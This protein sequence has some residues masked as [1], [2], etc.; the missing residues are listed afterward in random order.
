MTTSGLV[1]ALGLTA[2]PAAV[3]AWVLI[4]LLKPVM[5]RLALAKPNARSSHRLPTPQ[6][7]GLG[8][9][10]AALVVSGTGL[11]LTT[12]IDQAFGLLGLAVLGLTVLGFADDASP[13]AWRLKLV[14]QT[15]CCA[16][17]VAG[18]PAGLRLVPV[19]ILFW[20]ERAAMVLALVAMANI[21]NFIDGI[22]EIT[23]AH[24]APSLG[25][26]ALMGALGLVDSGSGV[27]AAAWLGAVAG[28]WLWNRHPARIFLG[29]S[30]SLPLGLVLGWFALQVG[31]QAA[32][33][34]GII[35]VLLPAADAAFTLLT[36][37]RRGVNVAEPHREHAYQQAVD[38]GLPVRRV[39]ATVAI[40]STALG[41]LALVACLAPHP[42]MQTGA[43]GLALCW[44]AIPIIG[45]LRRG[46]LRPAPGAAA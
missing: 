27:T 23:A 2:A 24:A 1:A 17:A 37:F 45:W 33:V 26:V 39:T 6:G 36:R 12:G 11:A 4:R 31:M 46:A 28:F 34:A 32:F 7:A 44:V 10:A 38:S 13:L 19:D 29:D 18:L 43:L 40:V 30:G 20:P 25:A 8:L 22:D 14:V 3:L 41:V 42:V 21:T 9:V 16:L 5:M 35:L 15:L